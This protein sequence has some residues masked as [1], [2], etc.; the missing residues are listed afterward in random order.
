MKGKIFISTNL[1]FGAYGFSREYR[2]KVEKRFFTEKIGTSTLNGIL[3]MV[4][5]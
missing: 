3:Y 2:A 4:P 5:P 1:L